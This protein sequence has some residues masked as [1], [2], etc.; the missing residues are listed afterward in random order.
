[1]KK[2]AIALFAALA[3]SVTTFGVIENA[4]AQEQPAANSASGNKPMKKKRRR[5]RRK[6]A[7]PPSGAVLP[8]QL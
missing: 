1:M 7:S 2:V 8:Q 6:P 5:R 4:Y 3:L